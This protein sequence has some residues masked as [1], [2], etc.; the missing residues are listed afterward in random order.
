MLHVATLLTI[1][2]DHVEAF[3][4]HFEA[5]AYIGVLLLGLSVACVALCV[6]IIRL[7][8]LAWYAGALIQVA[9]VARF[10]LA[11]TTGLPG[12]GEDDW[13]DPLAGVPLGAIALAMEAGFLATLMAAFAAGGAP[14]PTD[15]AA[16]GQASARCR[17][18]RWATGGSGVTSR[19]I[20]SEEDCVSLRAQRGGG[21]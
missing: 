8:A 3:P 12:Y 9:A 13:L 4:N 20:C 11:R 16:A 6:G 19:S 5:S 21:S 7:L 17:F 1:S 14:P 2:A 15:P 18:L 10:V